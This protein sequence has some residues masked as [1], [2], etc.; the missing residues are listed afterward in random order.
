MSLLR[1][2]GMQWEF[3]N[4]YERICKRY[5]TARA[6]TQPVGLTCAVIP[7]ARVNT[8]YHFLVEDVAFR[9][10][11]SLIIEAHRRLREV[12]TNYKGDDAVLILCPI[13]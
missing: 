3:R 8:D 2:P 10:E 13:Q 7:R 9:D 4:V 6:Y 1:E 5:P 12:R 11:V